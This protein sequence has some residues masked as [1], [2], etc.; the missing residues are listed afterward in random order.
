MLAVLQVTLLLLTAWKLQSFDKRDHEYRP[1]IS[2]VAACW[3]G[4]CL[5]LAVA[6]VLAWPETVT[7]RCVMT[8]VIAGASC[9]AAYHSGG[10]VAL[11]LRRLRIIR[12]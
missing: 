1:I 9:A 4:A 3:A 11:L 5:S 8:T 10:N 2:F 12:H 7:A 6:I